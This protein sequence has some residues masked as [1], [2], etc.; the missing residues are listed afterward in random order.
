MH[1]FLTRKMWSTLPLPC[2]IVFGSTVGCCEAAIDVSDW[3]TPVEPSLC[4]RYTSAWWDPT[5]QVIKPIHFTQI[6][7]HEVR[8][9]FNSFLQQHSALQKCQEYPQAN[10]VQTIE[11]S[12]PW[13]S[14]GG[15]MPSMLSESDSFLSKQI[16]VPLLPH[17]DSAIPIII[18]TAELTSN[19]ERG[20][21]WRALVL[22]RNSSERSLDDDRR[23]TGMF[24]YTLINW[25]FN[26]SRIYPLV[27][28][29]FYC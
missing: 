3:R 2:V 23:L 20:R 22:L 8:L 19:Y 4:V 6:Y 13:S 10:N 26:A 1:I 5:A 9:E 21:F 7:R 14:L 24:L 15:K 12:L 17:E 25:F 27:K 11:I 28:M 16:S 29:S 18:A